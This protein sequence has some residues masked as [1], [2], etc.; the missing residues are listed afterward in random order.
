MDISET[1]II[2]MDELFSLYGC[3]NTQ[4][5]AQNKRVATTFIC[6]LP[7][8]QREI[9]KNATKWRTMLGLTSQYL[10]TH[11]HMPAEAKQYPLPK[12][13]LFHTRWN[14]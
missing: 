8:P 10:G 12:T 6:H 9:Y 1:T 3:L 4:D 7:F 11:H 14:R 2:T 13:S 5:S